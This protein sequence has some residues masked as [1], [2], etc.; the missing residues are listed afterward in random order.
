[1]ADPTSIVERTAPTYA[2]Q[3]GETWDEL[4]PRRQR[5]WRALAYKIYELHIKNK[6]EGMSQSV[7]VLDSVLTAPSTPKNWL[8]GVQEAKNAMIALNLAAAMEL[9]THADI[10]DAFPWDLTEEDP[11]IELRAGDVEPET[12]SEHERCNAQVDDWTCTRRR[13]PSH[14]KHWDADSSEIVDEDGDEMPELEGIIL[15]TWYD[16]RKLET[17]HPVIGFLDEE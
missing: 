2:E 12:V 15:S 1:M 5:E 3:M 16:G 6:L 10:P 17:L 7:E 14:W 11:Y 9:R 8:R 4:T 13:H